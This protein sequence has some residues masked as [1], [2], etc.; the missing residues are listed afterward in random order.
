VTSLWATRRL[1]IPFVLAALCLLAT[2][3]TGPVLTLT[4]MI[5]AFGFVIDGATL[6]WSRSGGMAGH[7]Q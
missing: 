3:W 7:R 6:L 4:C 5:A 1:W 2:R